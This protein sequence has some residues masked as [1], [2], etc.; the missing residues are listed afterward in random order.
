MSA[1]SVERR[2]PVEIA[3]DTYVVQAIHGEGEGPLAV[4]MNAMVIRGREPVIVDTGTPLDRESILEQVFGLVDPED[5]RWIFITHDDID[6]YGNLQ[7]LMDACPRATLVASW[8]L[9]SRMGV[10]PGMPSPARWR[11]VGDGEGFDTGDRV[12][13]A[14]R[15]PLYDSPTTRGLFDPATG[16]YWASD[17][18][19][20]P[21]A[22]ATSFVDEIDSAD[23]AHGFT[24]FQ[25]WN[26]PWVDM[27]DGPRFHAEVERLRAVGVQTIA[28]CHGP[29]IG[30]G[31]VDRAFELLHSVPAAQVPPQ[32][33][34]PVL[35]EIVAALEATALETTALAP[36]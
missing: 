1:Q 30:S 24:T 32:P 31:M 25:K 28:T 5:V 20:T 16:V 27:V 22:K 13:R 2:S 8:Y 18:F 7:V 35:D 21:V 36:A 12:L 19:A 29:T 6:H 33:G 17:C 23:W 15:P 14:I 34:Q 11:W 26:S 10:E 9:T 3:A 4:H